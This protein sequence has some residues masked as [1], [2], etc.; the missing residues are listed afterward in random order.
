MP[1]QQMQ[2]LVRAHLDKYGKAAASNALQ[3]AKALSEMGDD[4]GAEIWRRIAD[5]VASGE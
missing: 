5:M 3:R 2:V 1:D 4:E